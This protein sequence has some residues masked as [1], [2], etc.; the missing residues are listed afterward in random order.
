MCVRLI[1]MNFH[2]IPDFIKILYNFMNFHPLK[3]EAF[4]IIKFYEN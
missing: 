1:K 3:G 2:K 4:Q